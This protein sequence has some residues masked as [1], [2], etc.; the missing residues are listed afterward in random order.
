MATRA[1]T[2]KLIRKI[3][4]GI[5]KNSLP[6]NIVRIIMWLICIGIISP[7]DEKVSGL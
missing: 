2:K 7:G 4:R 1:A 6:T 3:Q 5:T